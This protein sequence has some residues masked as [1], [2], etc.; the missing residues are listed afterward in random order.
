MCGISQSHAANH[1]QL[2]TES[3]EQHAS[4]NAVSKTAKQL[5]SHVRTLKQNSNNKTSL[6]T[7][8]VGNW[9]LRLL[10]TSPT[11]HLAYE[12]FCLLD[13]SPIGQFA[14]L[15]FRLLPGQFAYRL[16]ILPTKL[17]EYSDV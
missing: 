3:C 9:L 16:P 2:L 13:S 1:H 14:Y 12:T 4:S 8:L 11:G 15:T 6:L 17:P 7:Q 10:D 5:V